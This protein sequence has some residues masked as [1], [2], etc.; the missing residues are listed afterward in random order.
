MEAEISFAAP[1]DHSFILDLVTRVWTMGFSYQ[2]E[3]M[4]GRIVGKPWQEKVSDAVRDYLTSPGV[5]VLKAKIDGHFAGFMA[6]RI[7]SDTRIGE[8]GYNAVSPEYTGRGL[9]KQML[10]AALQK[11]QEAG[12]EHVE[13]VTG[14]NAG[15]LPARKMYESAGFSPIQESIRYTLNLEAYK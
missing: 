11:L 7:H 1:S 12:M 9:G 4:Y 2:Q 10:Q 8:I 13:V 5:S 3:Q 14:L 15:H 6:Y